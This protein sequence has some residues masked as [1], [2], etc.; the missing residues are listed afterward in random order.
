[1]STSIDIRTFLDSLV[2]DASIR[3]R[4]SKQKADKIAARRGE[5]NECADLDADV[6]AHW[7]EQKTVLRDVV[8]ALITVAKPFDTT[9]LIVG[10]PDHAKIWVPVTAG[11]VRALRAALDLTGSA[12]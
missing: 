5:R 10:E 4:R 1:M 9:E 3:A 6:K 7:M 12:A 8:C 2:S 11:Q